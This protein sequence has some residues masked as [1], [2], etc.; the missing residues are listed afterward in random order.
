[1]LAGQYAAAYAATLMFWTC[2]WTFVVGA[3]GVAVKAGENVGLGFFIVRVWEMLRGFDWSSSE[4]MLKNLLRFVGW[5]HIAS[6]ALLLLAWK[7]VSRADGIARQLA[8][9]LILTTAAMFVLLAYQGHGWGYR[10]L[11]GL[12]GN[13]SLLAGYGW[14]AAT[15]PGH[16]LRARAVTAVV[17]ASV[18]TILVLLPLRLQ[19]A[20]EFMAP[21]RAAVEEIQAST[22]DVVVVDGRDIR[23]GGDLVRNGALLKVKPK[24][25]DYAELLPRQLEVLCS[26]FSMAAFDRDDASR[27]GIR[28]EWALR[29]EERD[30]KPRVRHALLESGCPPSPS[31]VQAELRPHR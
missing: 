31:G 27:L 4:L 6:L 14:L 29:A 20:H 9:G 16:Q 10:Y 26:R 5:Q 15:S 18:V 11:H 28:R 3:A 21:Y 8:G 23:F 1:M 24:I 13:V 2:Y 30:S 12:L 7:A 19:Q 25:L 22:V 17:L